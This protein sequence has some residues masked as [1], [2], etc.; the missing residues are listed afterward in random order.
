M[1]R[2]SIC[3]VDLDNWLINAGVEPEFPGKGAGGWGGG[4]GTNLQLRLIVMHGNLFTSTC[5]YK[6]MYFSYLAPSSPTGLM[7]LDIKTT[8]MTISWQPP[9]HLNGI[10][11]GYQVSYTPHG[12]SECLHDVVGDTTSTELT[13]LKPHTEYTICVRAKTVDF[14]DYSTLIT[15]NTLEDGQLCYLPFFNYCALIWGPR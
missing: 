11:R 13:S 14:G 1:T 12:E 15:V 10:I 6:Y 9:H 3:P 8:S 7:A 2:C 4:G 5:M